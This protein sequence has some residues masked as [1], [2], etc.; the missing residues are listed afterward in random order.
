MLFAFKSYKL[1]NSNVLLK[2]YFL[3]LNKNSDIL[4]I[5]ILIS[6]VSAKWIVLDNAW[7]LFILLGTKNRIQYLSNKRMWFGLEIWMDGGLPTNVRSIF[8]MH[9]LTWLTDCRLWTGQEEARSRWSGQIHDSALILF[10]SST[11]TASSL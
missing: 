9:E 6:Y 3:L 7:Y 10:H 11:S 2:K 4:S 1:W 8:D 5:G